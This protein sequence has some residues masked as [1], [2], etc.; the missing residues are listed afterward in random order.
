MHIFYEVGLEA[1]LAAGA[2]VIV[3]IKG[4]IAG[5][6][7]VGLHIQR[8]TYKFFHIPDFPL[9]ITAERS[10]ATPCG[11]SKN[12]WDRNPERLFTQYTVALIMADEKV[13][14]LILLFIHR[15]KG[16]HAGDAWRT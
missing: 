16:T 9:V 2:E 15:L 14:L 8:D 3:Y 4:G 1:G 6:V 11:V 5:V 7:E 13:M 10:L 12:P